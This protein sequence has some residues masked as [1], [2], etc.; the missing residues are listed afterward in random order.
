MNR[1]QERVR[2]LAAQVREIAELDIQKKNI[3]LW[4][5]INDFHMLR[6]QEKG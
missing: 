3:E 6:Q 5:G 4:K 2:S 1:E